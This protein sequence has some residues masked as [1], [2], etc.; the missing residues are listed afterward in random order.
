MVIDLLFW[1]FFAIGFLVMIAMIVNAFRMIIEG[2]KGRA[3]WRP[4]GGGSS[5]FL[6]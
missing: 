4:F 2:R 3:S 6:R 5:S 1:A